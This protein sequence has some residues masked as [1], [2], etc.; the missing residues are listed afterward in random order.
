VR[1]GFLV[2]EVRYSRGIQSTGCCEHRATVKLPRETG[3]LVAE[4]HLGMICYNGVA[5]LA[6]RRFAN[7][8]VRMV[9]CAAVGSNR[10]SNL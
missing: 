7:T 5:P 1:N 10:L 3:V 4:S 6:G 2:H 8:S 9:R